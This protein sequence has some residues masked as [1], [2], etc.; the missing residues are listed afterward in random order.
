MLATSS[1]VL[2]MVQRSRLCWVSSPT[3]VRNPTAKNTPRARF[4]PLQIRPNLELCRSKPIKSD[5]ACEI[6]LRP[7]GHQFLVRL[8]ERI[9]L[10][11]ARKT[12]ELGA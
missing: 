3:P 7:S 12:V 2:A 8:G 6:I 4:K 11:Q 1:Y 10:D 9:V 5:F